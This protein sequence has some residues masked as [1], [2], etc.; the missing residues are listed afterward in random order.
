LEFQSWKDL[1][2]AEKFK[3]IGDYL[4]AGRIRYDREPPVTQPVHAHQTAGHRRSLL[5]T[6]RPPPR[7]RRWSPDRLIPACGHAEA[8]SS[9]ASS[10]PQ[11]LALALSVLACSSRR[12]ATRRC[13]AANR[14]SSPPSSVRRLPP[15][16]PTPLHELH[17]VGLSV[18]KE[19]AVDSHCLPSSSPA[20]KSTSTALLH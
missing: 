17:T 5:S 8:K 4:S 20:T 1:K 12:R 13:Q 14:R 18:R 3:R 15:C 2:I 16:L 6:P 7:R 11:P 9:F 19:F 10:L